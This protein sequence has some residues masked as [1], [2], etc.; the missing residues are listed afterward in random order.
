MIAMSWINLGDAAQYQGDL[1]RA[2]AQYE[3]GFAVVRSLDHKLLSAS[4]LHKMGNLATAQGAPSRAIEWLQESLATWQQIGSVVGIITCVEAVAV[5]VAA[6]AETIDHMRDAIMLWGVAEAQRAVG[7]TPRRLADSHFYAPF[8]EAARARMGEAAYD[9]SLAIGKAMPFDQAISFVKDLRVD[10]LPTRTREPVKPERTVSD[11]DLLHSLSE[12]ERDV[13]R[14][15][16][17]G[18]SDK[19]VAARLVISPRTVQTHLTSIYSKLGVNSRHAATVFAL[20]HRLV[21]PATSN[22]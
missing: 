4:L 10:P 1:A 8:I 20:E 13:L 15:V 17:G 5:A 3:A 14:L 6:C 18:L 2:R 12:R 11:D 16:A 7:E 22:K 21:S 9:V 19:E